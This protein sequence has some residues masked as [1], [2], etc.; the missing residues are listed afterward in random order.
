MS[1]RNRKYLEASWRAVDGPRSFFPFMVAWDLVSLYVVVL[2]PFLSGGRLFDFVIIASGTVDPCDRNL[3]FCHTAAQYRSWDFPFWI[4]KVGFNMGSLSW[5]GFALVGVV[6]VSFLVFL[7]FFWLILGIHLIVTSS[8]TIQLRSVTCILQ[9]EISFW[10][11][12]GVF[13]SYLIVQ[14]GFL[15][16]VSI[17]F[18]GFALTGGVRS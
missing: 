6:R 17:F 10:D 7:F 12:E 4:K 16:L 15:I 3:F 18:G 9:I 2:A 14:S 11:Q 1:L 8:Y 13:L 5:L